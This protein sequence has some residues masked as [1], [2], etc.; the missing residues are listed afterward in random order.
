VSGR[1]SFVTFEEY[2]EQ[3]WDMARSRSNQLM[4]A[5]EAT[6]HLKTS[7]IV[8]TLPTRESHVRELLHL[9]TDED[10]AA[11]W[12]KVV[13]HRSKSFSGSAACVW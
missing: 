2:V 13:D 11:V 12:Q 1:Y 9:E 10:R 7:T 6:D 3:R 5:A 4:L 8:D